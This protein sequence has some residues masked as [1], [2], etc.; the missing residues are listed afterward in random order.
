MTRSRGTQVAEDFKLLKSEIIQTFSGL[1]LGTKDKATT[2]LLLG[3]GQSA[4]GSRETTSTASVNFM[5]FRLENSATSGDNR[6]MYLRLYLTGA[7]TGGEAARIFT[8]IEDVAAANAH[9]A[10]ISLNFGTSGSI[11][12]Q[13]IA[14]RNTLHIPNAALSGG[15]YAALQAEIYADGASSDIS[16]ATSHALFRGVVGGNST[17]A[18]TVTNFLDLSVPAPGSGKLV[19]TDITTHT[20]YGGLAVNING[21]IKYLALVSD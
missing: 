12:G 18:A 14:G 9:G 3:A 21:T 13:G 15:T 17:G 2:A 5:E 7:G 11:T 4:A 8:T 10:H 20:A 6:G 19:D 1:T 16:G